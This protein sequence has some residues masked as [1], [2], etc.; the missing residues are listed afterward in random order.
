MSKSPFPNSGGQYAQQWLGGVVGGDISGHNNSASVCSDDGDFFSPRKRLGWSSRGLR[1]PRSIAL[2]SDND[3]WVTSCSLRLVVPIR[4]ASE[5][6]NLRCWFTNSQ[7]FGMTQ[8]DTVYP[9][10]PACRS[11]LTRGGSR[12]RSFPAPA[13]AQASARF[14]VT[15]RAQEGQVAAELRS[16][17][18]GLSRTSRWSRFHCCKNRVPVD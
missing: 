14:T 8:A 15:G 6:I 3:R 7:S 13:S 12:R 9:S 17:R 10:S 5:Q 11:V 2:T 4:L 18:L 16:T 1:V